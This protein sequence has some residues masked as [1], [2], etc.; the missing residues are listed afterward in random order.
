M[1]FLPGRTAILRRFH[2]APFAS[3][4]PEVWD[5]FLERSNLPPIAAVAHRALMIHRLDLRS[6]LSEIRQPILLVCG[7]YDPLVGLACEEALLHGLPNAGRARLAACGHNPLFSHPEVLAEL[8]RQF[9]TPPAQANEKPTPRAQEAHM[10][11][12]A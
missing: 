4:P 6:L 9:L 10:A 12:P 3:R 7:E 8:I 2:F 5:Y 1:H 11:N